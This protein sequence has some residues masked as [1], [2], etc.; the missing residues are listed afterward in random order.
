LGL[1]EDFE[2]GCGGCLELVS[3]E[4]AQLVESQLDVEEMHQWKRE[5]PDEA[6]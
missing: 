6:Q 2:G 5:A 1:S 4:K 3:V